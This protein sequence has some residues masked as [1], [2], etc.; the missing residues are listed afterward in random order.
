MYFRLLSFATTVDGLFLS[1]LALSVLKGK[2]TLPIAVADG[3]VAQTQIY[4]AA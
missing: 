3:R 1:D 2:Q 4:T